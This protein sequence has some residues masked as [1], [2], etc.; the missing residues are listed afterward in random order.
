MKKPIKR[1][2]VQISEELWLKLWQEV[3]RRKTPITI[4]DLVRELCEAGLQK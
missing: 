2:P 1:H 4:P 3:R